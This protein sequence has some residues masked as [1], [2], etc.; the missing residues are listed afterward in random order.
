MV[1]VQ[2]GQLSDMERFSVLDLLILKDFFVIVNEMSDWFLCL[3]ECGGGL[4]GQDHHFMTSI[5]TLPC[6]N[7]T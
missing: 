7:V 4:M 6:D 2:L 3:G 1:F 5:L